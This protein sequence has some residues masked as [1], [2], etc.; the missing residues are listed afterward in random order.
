ML[1]RMDV[2][3]ELEMEFMIDVLGYVASFLVFATF[4][5]RK[6]LTLR[7]LAIFSNVAF[8]AYSLGYHLHPIFILHTALLPLNIYRVFE[9][10]KHDSRFSL[11]A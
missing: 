11:F 3:V 10:L 6:I 2:V 8:I 7:V 1:N 5:V 4:Y 9:L